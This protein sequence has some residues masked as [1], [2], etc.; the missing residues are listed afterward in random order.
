MKQKYTQKLLD[1]FPELYRGRNH[2]VTK[3]LMCFGFECGDGWY[4]IIHSL[5][6]DIMKIVS[7]DGIDVPE[8]MQV[9]E[10]FGGL[11]FYAHGSNEWVNQ[12]ILEAEEASMETCEVCGKPGRRRP[13]GWI[14]TVCDTHA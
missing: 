11:R 3:S 12:R 7:D 8:V 2:S 13:G 5:S 9:K 14:R 4:Q 10:K 6:V 1:E